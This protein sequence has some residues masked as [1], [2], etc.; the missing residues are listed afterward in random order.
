MVTTVA[1]R[2]ETTDGR[3]LAEMQLELDEVS[4][5][6]ELIAARVRQEVHDHVGRDGGRALVVTPGEVERALNGRSGGRFRRVDADRQVAVAY[7]AFERGRVL[8]L[9]D[10]EQVTD[11]DAPL[12]LH[13][14]STVSFLKLVPLVGG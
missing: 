4:T 11:L 12:W 3:I 13:P 14:G 1:V 10:D 9:I 7:D 2:D 5:V 6:A 8:L